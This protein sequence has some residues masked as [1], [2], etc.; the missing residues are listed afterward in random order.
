MAAI[1]SAVSTIGRDPI[2][3]GSNP[4]SRPLT[5]VFLFYA[6]GYVAQLEEATDL[7]PVQVWVRL[8]P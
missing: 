3:F 6:N 4:N 8:P 7:N 2:R 5:I 1:V